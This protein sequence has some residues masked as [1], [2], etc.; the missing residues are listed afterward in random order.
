MSKTKF[1]PQNPNFKKMVESRIRGNHFMN[2]VGIEITTIEPGFV[3]GELK[4]R[5]ELLQQL[6]FVH[7][8]VSSTLADVVMGFAAY[9]LVKEGQGVVTVDLKVNFVSPGKGEKLKAVGRVYKAGN[10]LFFCEGEIYVIH[11]NTELLIAKSDSIM[12]VL[13]PEDYLK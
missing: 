1:I 2:F 7:G 8:G 10:K 11:G 9:S 3:E 13:N 12:T 6:G 5:D 4:L